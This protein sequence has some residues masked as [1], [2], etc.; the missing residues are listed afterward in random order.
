[1]HRYFN[2]SLFLCFLLLLLTSYSYA[3]NLESRKLGNTGIK[4]SMLG[5]TVATPEATME[6]EL[7][8]EAIKNGVNL[9]DVSPY[10]KG[11]EA[12]VAENLGF[13]TRSKVVLL[14]RWQ[15]PLQDTKD[16]EYFEQLFASSLRK[17]N[18]DCIELVM[19]DDIYDVR[20]LNGSAYLN[21]FKKLRKEGKTKYL[22]ISI[23]NQK[24]QLG[25]ILSRVMRTGDFDFVMLEYTAKNAA[26]NLPIATA[27]GRKGMGV[28]F[29]NTVESALQN[30]NT[31]RR[32]TRRKEMPIEQ[33]AINW[34]VNSAQHVTSVLVTPISKA[35]FENVMAG[36]VDTDW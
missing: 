29:S 30:E 26:E 11:A 36:A 7:F 28:L 18:T 5:I 19:L 3:A 17:L 23:S 14:T 20:Q 4:L 35:Q 16:E 25:N 27:I 32:I 21:V 34:A 6:P 12:F 24:Y 8:R 31:T 13:S 33:A 1:M 10:V 2:H 22:G 9:I 15:N